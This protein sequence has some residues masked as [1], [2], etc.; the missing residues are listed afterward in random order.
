MSQTTPMAAANMQSDRMNPPTLL[1]LP[2]EIRNQIWEQVYQPTHIHDPTI[3]WVDTWDN[4]GPW[5][6]LGLSQTCRQTRFETHH[7][8]WQTT[9]IK[10][11]LEKPPGHPDAL[12]SAYR[13]LRD[14]GDR[15]VRHMRRFTV[16]R[17][18]GMSTCPAEDGCSSREDETDD[19]PVVDAGAPLEEA[20]HVHHGHIPEMDLCLLPGRPVRCQVVESF[21]GACACCDPFAFVDEVELCGKAA[22]AWGEAQE[23]RDKGTL[24]VEDLIAAFEAVLEAWGGGNPR[25]ERITEEE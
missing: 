11:T 5:T 18:H 12:K 2:G 3:S 14:M 19:V 21:D 17:C 15:N 9:G 25:E 20:H 16:E 22:V 10:F 23:K 1:N 13:W 8:A 24:G 7:L 6:H 4:M